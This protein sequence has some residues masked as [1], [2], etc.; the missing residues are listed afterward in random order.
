MTRSPR[1]PIV[2]GT[3]QAAGPLAGL[4]VVEIGDGT[5]GPFAAKMLG[6]FGADVIKVEPPEG[7][8]SRRRG[9]FPNGIVDPEASGLFHYLNTNKRS[10]TIDLDLESGRAALEGLVADAD[11]LVSNLPGEKLRMAGIAPGQLRQRYPRL[12]VTTILPFGSEGPWAGRRGDELVTYAMGG[13][14]YSTPGMPDAADD[15]E[16]EPPLHPDCFAAETI[17]GIVAATGTLAAAHSRTLTGT[18]CHVD[19]S[20]QA[21]V[22]VMQQRE[23]TTCS[24]LGTRYNRLVNA[25]FFGRMPNFYL[26]CKDGHVVLAAPVDHQWDRLVAAMGSPDWASDAVFATV[27]ARGVNWSELRRRLIEWTMTLTGA[28]LFRLAGELKV[29]FFPFYSLSLM[30]NSAHVAERGSLVE[31]EIGGRTARMPGAPIGLRRTPWTLRRPAPRLGEHN[32]AIFRD[33]LGPKASD[34]PVDLERALNGTGHAL[35]LVGLRVLDLGQF[36]AMPFC[37]QWL[38]WLG[39]E[40][41]VIESRKHFTSRTAPP[42]AKGHEGQPD[43]SGYFNML[44]GAKKSC[45]VDMTTPAGRDLVRRIAGQSDVLVDNFSTGVME[46]LGLGWDVVS[47]L[48]PSLIMLSCG[49][50]GRTGPLK[51]A[52][53]FHSAV[54]LFS[55]VAD[56]TGYAGGHPRLMGGCLPDPMGGA[57]SVFA[58]LAALRHRDATGQG[59]YIDLAMYESML[60]LIPEAVIDFTLNG[61]EPMR[62]GNRDRVKAPH[63]IYRCRDADTWVA[64]SVHDD[65]DWAAFCSAAGRAEWTEDARFRDARLRISN[66]AALDAAVEDWTRGHSADHVTSILQSAGLAAGPVLRTDQLIDDPQLNAL[67]LVVATDHPIAGRHRQLGLPWRMDSVG[68]EYRRAPLLGEHTREVLTGLIGVS[69]TEY[70]RLEA[71]G[72]LS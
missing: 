7:D 20:Q 54:N 42:F 11:I 16:R 51:G 25:T 24:Y 50:F 19:V 6:D 1:P 63:G 38:G 47:Q 41:I 31:V 29:P 26:P 49:A 56:V 8:G 14:A 15:L 36:I 2:S 71:D 27:G 3:G 66:G 72:V 70:A 61:T 62:A 55:G 59:Q 68:V 17:A 53:G 13:I 60:T 35:P 37:T 40:V 22:A 39:A 30:A 57:Y 46:K 10:V 5:A 32:I 21:A 65:Q 58:I 64:I 48:K 33:G 4:A 23:V 12:I 45:T 44:Y 28:E 34:G 52:Q 18:G 43:G 69:A 67:G 9:P